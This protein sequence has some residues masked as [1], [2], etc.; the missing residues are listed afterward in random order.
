[1]CSCQVFVLI[2]VFVGASLASTYVVTSVYETKGCSGN[3]LSVEA[4]LTDACWDGYY[5]T[6]VNNNAN[7]RYC[8]KS[9]CSADCAEMSWFPEGCE[10]PD[11]FI[12][13]TCSHSIP[14]VPTHWIETRTFINNTKCV[15]EPTYFEAVPPGKCDG[16]SGDM[17]CAGNSITYLYACS[18][19]SCNSGCSNS[20]FPLGCVSSGS[21]S[22]EYFCT[23][24]GPQLGDK[25]TGL[26]QRPAFWLIVGGVVLT[27]TFAIT[28]AWMDWR[29]KSTRTTA[30]S[31]ST[32]TSPST[33]SSSLLSPT[34]VFG[35][36]P[37]SQRASYKYQRIS[38]TEESVGES[39]SDNNN[40]NNA[41]NDDDI[42]GHDDI[43]ETPP[44]DGAETRAI[45]ISHN[46]AKAPPTLI[47][48]SHSTNNTNSTNNSNDNLLAM[49]RNAA[50]PSARHGTPKFLSL[51]H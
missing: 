15:G 39:S 29:A 3:V 11:C 43:I 17:Q 32:N 21:I 4:Y 44:R 33:T 19:D 38:T 36:S 8:N 42:G 1:M 7:V 6:C 50:T 30:S 51:S 41:E 31:S 37:S 16:G 48:L 25:V 12:N 13:S 26:L 49:V 5:F 14:T 34:A 28:A 46:E 23:A 40:N 47:T 22:H 9:D 45:N 10:C 20:S 35:V 24:P 2:L 18:N 27:L